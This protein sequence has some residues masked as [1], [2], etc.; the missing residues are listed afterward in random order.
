MVSK[1]TQVIIIYSVSTT[2]NSIPS[3][4][5]FLSFKNLVIFFMCVPKIKEV[6]FAAVSF[7]FPSEQVIIHVGY[8][9]TNLFVV[10]L[11]PEI[12]KIAKRE[13]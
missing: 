3:L 13:H 11:K 5:S 8:H 9:K 4:V 10:L 1:G 7:L 6:V 12:L 2:S